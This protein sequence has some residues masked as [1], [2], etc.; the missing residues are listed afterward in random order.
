[1]NSSIT[2]FLMVSKHTKLISISTHL[3]ND[4]IA[5][6]CP[7]SLYELIQDVLRNLSGLSTAGGSTNDDHWVV[8]N[9]GHD[10]LLEVLDRQ[11]TSL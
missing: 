10:L 6:R 1:M 8:V 3:R 9:G 4:D 7:A 11:L 2:V 5:F